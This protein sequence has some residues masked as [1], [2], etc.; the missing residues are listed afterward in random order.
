MTPPDSGDDVMRE[1]NS[2]PEMDELCECGSEWGE[3]CGTACP[4]GKRDWRSTG[5]R[6]SITVPADLAQ[7]ILAAL[8]DAASSKLNLLAAEL[9]AAVERK[10]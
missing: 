7:R 10:P 5:R 8:E 1:P 3:H 9:R 2:K 6:G 4:D